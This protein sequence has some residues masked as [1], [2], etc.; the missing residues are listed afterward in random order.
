MIKRNASSVK[1]GSGVPLRGTWKAVAVLAVLAF[2][3]CVNAADLTV[4]QGDDPVT[5]D[6]NSTYDAVVVNGELTVAPGETLTCTSLT[7]ADNI[8]GTAKLVVGDGATVTVTGTDDNATKIG[9]GSGRAEVYLGTGAKFT[10][11]KSGY[12]NFCY[13]YDSAPDASVTAM[14]ESLLVV[15]TNATLTCRR[16]CFGHDDNNYTNKPSSIVESYPPTNAVVRLDEGA[17]IS[18]YRI[19]DQL[20]VAKQVLFNGG[21]I[22]QRTSNGITGGFIR[23]PY[24]AK[25]SPLNLEGTNG[26]PISIELIDKCD[27]SAFANFGSADN[28]INLKGDGGF[29]KT[30]AAIFPLANADKYWAALRPNIRCLF[31]GDFV[32]REGGFSVATDAT[33]INANNNIFRTA[34]NSYSRP[35]DMVVESEAVFDLA[36]ADCVMNS[37][38]ALGGVVTN[39]ADTSATLTIGVL[40]DGRDSVITHVKP[41]IAIVK[42]G[43]AALTL[44]GM[45]STMESLD[46]QGG[47]LA[48]KDVQRMG[49]TFYRFQIDRIKY[50]ELDSKA[51]ARVKEF[52]FMAGGEDVTRPYKALHYDLSGAS[53]VVS[54]ENM[55]DGDMETQY[56]DLRASSSNADKRAKVGVTVE[57][58]DCRPVDSYR[59]APRYAYSSDTDPASWRVFGGYSK[60]NLTLLDQVTGFTVTDVTSDGWNATNFVCSYNNGPSALHIGTLKLA[61]D[62]KVVAAGA[63]I[64]CDTFDAAS[65]LELDLANGATVPLTAAQ[66]VS[67]ISVSPG[68]GITTVSVLNPESSGALHVTGTRQ[69]LEGALLSVG[70]CGNVGN[71]AAWQVYFNGGLLENRRLFY[72]NGEVRLQ[73]IGFMVSFR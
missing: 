42:K 65:G 37:V 8:S 32:I 71:L 41:E 30:G 68:K 70:S 62:A 19:E 66:S 58:A 55:L 33:K 40:D 2:A 6:A 72:A 17:E 11:T 25:K 50:A 38:R 9:V 3:A 21:R 59:W 73:P 47:T 46:M 60:D 18:V 14:T 64:S 69:A 16:F 31:T 57:Y 39:S 67:K 24:A 52:A 27:F 63:Q 35:V 5:I 13:G 28:I 49:Y 29:L 10:A 7:V 4:A 22:V 53:T 12:F 23:M 15:G 34:H 51:R 44:G 56:Y 54:P 1:T 26:C 36:G 43:N 20:P 45:D 48:M 61:N